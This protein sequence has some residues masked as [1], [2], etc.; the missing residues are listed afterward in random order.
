MRAV[1]PTGPFRETGEEKY[2]HTPYSEAYLT[3]DISGCF[4]V[5]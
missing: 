3:P 4:P 2:A 5:M 1:T